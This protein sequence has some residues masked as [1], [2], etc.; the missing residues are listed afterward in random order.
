MGVLLDIEQGATLRS[1]FA[2]LE[3]SRIAVVDA[4]E[5]SD[6]DAMLYDALLTLA[7]ETVPIQL[8]SPHP[9]I[10]TITIVEMSSDPVPDCAT[11]RVELVYRTQRF[12]FPPGGVGDGVDF[13]SIR[14][15]TRSGLT[16]IN[17]KD[18]SEIIATAP[19]VFATLGSQVKKVTIPR[20]VG[21]LIFNRIEG[22]H[23]TARM[24]LYTDT[25]NSIDLGFPV[26]Y[27]AGELYCVGI[28]ADTRTQGGEYIVRYEFEHDPLRKTTIDVEWSIPGITVR[29][30]EHDATSRF[31][32]AYKKEQNFN[33][34]GL[35]FSD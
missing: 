35:D 17:P 21:T 29:P 1:T 30:T 10:P 4:L 16:S 6:A 18:G 5:G 8:G 7:A 12:D 25:V 24:R 27:P 32:L 22:V 13:K 23:P 14:Y 33:L 20:S 31:E 3:T 11:A 26:T 9:T 34:L 19:T 2:G 15:G 28:T